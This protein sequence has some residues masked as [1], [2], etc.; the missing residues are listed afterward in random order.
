MVTSRTVGQMVRSIGWIQRAYASVRFNIANRKHFEQALA[1]SERR[2]RDLTE[3]ASDFF[4]EQNADLRFTLIRPS[5]DRPAPSSMIG[6]RLWECSI[7]SDANQ[8]R[9]Y[10]RQAEAHVAFSNL[11][12]GHFDEGGAS[13]GQWFSL[14][15]KPLLDSNGKFCGYQGVGR[16]VTDK[17]AAEETLRQ[18]ESELRMRNSSF[19]VAVSNMR[20]ALLAFNSSGKLDFANDRYSEMYGLKPEM[21]QP[22]CTPRELLELRKSAGTFPGDIEEWMRDLQSAIAEGK[23]LNR[24]VEL[25]NGR[26]IAVLDSPIPGGGWVSTHE[27][28]TERRRIER[29]L[30]HMTRHD[31]LTGL[32]NRLLLR[33]QLEQA[34]VGGSVRMGVAIFVLN[35]HRFKQVNETFGRAVGDELLRR[36]AGR[37][38]N[39]VR[40]SDIVARLDG[41]EFA[42]TQVATD[43]PSDATML[44]RRI[45]DVID[46]PFSLGGQ[47]INVGVRIGIALV[48]NDGSTPDQL[49]KN[50]EIALDRARAEAVSTYRFFDQ[51][52][53]NIV[54]AKRRMELELRSV[55]LNG[56]LDVVYQPFVNLT[57]DEVVGVEA[58]VRWHHPVRGVISPSE[59]IP[60]AEET[61]LI[62]PIGEWVLRKACADAARWPAHTTIAVNISV[63][64][65]KDRR[66]V[67]T[68]TSALAAS[69]LPPER[70]ELEIT[71]SVLLESN[72][73]TLSVLSR[74]RSIGIRIALDD[75]GTGY[76]SLSSVQSLSFD[77]IKIDRSFV[78]D[79]CRS[80][81]SQAIVRAMAG[82]GRSLDITTT[83]EGV[84]TP[85]QL[86]MVRTELC[87]EMQGFFFSVPRS[88][89]EIS[90]LFAKPETLADKVREAS[91]ARGVVLPLT[92]SGARSRTDKRGEWNK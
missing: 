22:G 70:L 45:C 90:R 55:L 77:K 62:V 51:E 5:A 73:S 53:D 52:I 92:H 78:T 16:C 59:F 84:E 50:A 65:I 18:R 20:Q 36:V 21:L 13:D 28:I 2:F 74:L 32:P 86:E 67:D 61:G 9:R 40:D 29:R 48:P 1:T 83:A 23:T 34:L 69:G 17:M 10:R 11:E 71:E 15:G 12:F 35:I 42:V 19:N 26:T 47:E 80:R 3:L 41:D 58:L 27:D 87:T 14:S 81:E 66:L 85:E 24:L 8:M 38:R 72:R 68:V 49:V 30:K 63:A 43:M 57:R 75:F 79:L 56:E 37:L 33:E 91:G 25:P 60:I 4:W 6:K 89:A 7:K 76:S 88:A 64:Q 39:C 46:A 54:T 82:L 44:A 31:S